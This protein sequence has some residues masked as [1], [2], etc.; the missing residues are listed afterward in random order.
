MTRCTTRSN[1]SAKLTPGWAFEAMSRLVP[2]SVPWAFMRF[3]LGCNCG[4]AE[5]M[6]R[7]TN[8]YGGIQ[9]TMRET[10]NC[11]AFKDN[12][13][14]S[15]PVKLSAGG[16]VRQSEG[17]FND[18]ILPWRVSPVGAL[19]LRCTTRSISKFNFLLP[20]MALLACGA[21]VAKSPPIRWG[22]RRRK[23]NLRARD[24]PVQ[25][26]RKQLPPLL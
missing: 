9:P 25:C 4:G 7:W 3:R 11:E 19:Q 1:H 5:V 16:N 18:E 26:L 20:V 15:R 12:L 24:H 6:S 2:R 8:E 21:A 22:G 10:P 23:R 13:T 17:F 14:P